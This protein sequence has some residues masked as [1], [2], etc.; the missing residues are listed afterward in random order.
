MAAKVERVFAQAGRPF[1]AARGGPARRR[2][3]RSR[4]R[5]STRRRRASAA[6]ASRTSASREHRA[7]DALFLAWEFARA[8]PHYLAAL[9]VQP[10]D[11]HAL[12][13]AAQIQER[14]GARRQALE[15]WQRVLVLRPDHPEA[16]ERAGALQPGR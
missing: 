11:L 6:S 4:R 8:L 16:R 7:G 12:V 2:A 1:P 14:L 10:T 15:L 9:E 5:P 3:R 13:R